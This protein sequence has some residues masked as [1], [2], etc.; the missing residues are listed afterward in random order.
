MKELINKYF[1]EAERLQIEAEEQR[2][3]AGA[4]LTPLFDLQHQLAWA[5][6]CEPEFKELE[7]W[8]HKPRHK[9]ATDANRQHSYY[10]F[11]GSFYDLC[12]WSNGDTADSIE[13]HPIFLTDVS[14]EEKKEVIR[15][16]YRADIAAAENQKQR[17]KE[18]ELE[19]AR[20]LLADNGVVF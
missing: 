4:I 10:T 14:D 12:E 2:R 5:V 11:D 9:F 17:T 16:A 13:L 8:W 15:Q 1:A 6:H 7:R 20:K 19:K 3:N 18:A